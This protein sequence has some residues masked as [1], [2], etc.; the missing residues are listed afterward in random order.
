M[1]PILLKEL[2][3]VLKERGNFI[4]LLAMPI[5]FIMMFASIFGGDDDTQITVHAVDLDQSHVSHDFMKQIDDIR[6]MELKTVSAQKLDDQLDEIKKGQQ[7]SL[8]VIPKGFQSDLKAGKQ[9]DLKLYQDPASESEVVPIQ[10]VLKN[11]SGAYREQKL[12]KTLAAAEQSKDQIKQT[13]TSPIQVKNVKTSSDHISGVDQVVPGMTVMFVFYIIISMARRFFKEKESGL[14]ARTQSTAVRPLQYLV[15]MWI[16]FVFTVIAQCVALFAFGHFVYDIKLGDLP[17]LA[18]I[19]LC[20]SICGTGIGLAISLLVSGET[21][22]MVVAQIIAMGGAMVGGL[23]VPS[24]LMPQAVQTIGHFTP[25]FWAQKSLQ[26]V[27]VHGAHIGNIVSALAILLA[28]GIAGL[29]VAFL[30]Y[31]GFLRSATN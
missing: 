9:T 2:K 23:W 26:D 31:P 25:Q 7:S 11:V 30:R 18:A 27:I 24:Y 12:T 6:G 13:L 8:L 14:L 4:F 16:P 15:G 28:F 29:V 5:V 22:A 17:S 21:V 1:K 19:I 20:L 10:S 3:I